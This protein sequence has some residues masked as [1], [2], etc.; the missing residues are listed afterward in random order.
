MVEGARER[1]QEFLTTIFPDRLG[2][3]IALKLWEGPKSARDLANELGVARSSIYYRIGELL[4]KGFVMKY[5]N[6]GRTMFILSSRVMGYL[7]GGMDSYLEE[8]EGKRLLLPT[9]KYPPALL[10]SVPEAE[11]GGVRGVSAGRRVIALALYGLGIVLFVLSH[12]RG[13]TAW[14]SQFVVGVAYLV[15]CWCLAYS[16]GGSPTRILKR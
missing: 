5:Q 15:V 2:L 13:M 7:A 12:Y 9:P 1:Y 3:D 8:V 11:R 16:V 4:K 14:A 10:P 6:K